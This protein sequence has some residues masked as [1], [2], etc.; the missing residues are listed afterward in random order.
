MVADLYLCWAHYYDYCD[1]FEK[2]ESV[3]RKGLDARA[4][5]IELIEQAHRQFGFQMSQRLL[6]KDEST[7]NKFRSSMEE[8]RLALTSLRAHRHRHVGSMRTGSAVKNHQPGRVEQHDSLIRKSNRKVQ[9][10]EDTGDAPTSPTASTSVVQSILNSTKKQENLREPGPWNKAKMKTTALFGGASA[11]KPSFP[12]LEDDAFPPIPLPD[13]ENN[14]ARGIQLPNDFIRKNLPQNEFLVPMHQD[15]DPAKNTIYRYDKFMV[16]PAADKS[17]SLEELRAYKWFKKHN[18]KNDFTQTQDAVWKNG[19][20]IPIRLPPHFVRKNAKQDD[21]TLDPINIEDALANG[22]RKFAFDINLIYTPNE[23]FSVEEILQ[24]KWLNG[25]LM[26]QKEAEMEL[27]CGFER[28][29]EIYNRNANR[30]SM[31]LGGRKSILPR[32]SN[33]PRKSMG[34]RKSIGVRQSLAP[35]PSLPEAVEEPQ[36]SL[37]GIGVAGGAVNRFSLPKRKSIYTAHTLETLTPI[38]ETPS[39]PCSR[40]KLEEDNEQASANHMKPTPV[41]F[42][43]FEDGEPTENDEQVFKVPQ[44]APLQKTRISTGFQDEDLDGCTTQTFNFFIKSQA[45][46]TPKVDKQHAKFTEPENISALQKGLDF[47][48]DCETSPG[49]EQNAAKQPFACGGSGFDG[50]PPFVL[51]QHEIYRQKLS[52]IMETT[53]ECATVSS[54][55]ATASSKSSSADDFDFTKHTNHQSSAAMSTYRQQTIINNTA[56]MSSSNVSVMSNRG[57]DTKKG[58]AFDIYQEDA[59]K[60]NNTTVSQQLPTHT[61]KIVDSSI[62][63]CSESDL[64]TFDKT[65]PAAAQFHIYEDEN[66]KKLEINEMQS[67]ESKGDTTLVKD[68]DPSNSKQNQ[69]VFEMS[70]CETAASAWSSKAGANNDVSSA[71]L[72]LTAASISSKIQSQSQPQQPPKSG[73][74]VFQEDTGLTLPAINFVEDRTAHLPFAP[75]IF[76]QSNLT[77]MMPSEKTEV[78]SMFMP[79]IPDIADEDA[80]KNMSKF[81]EHNASRVEP[82]QPINQSAVYNRSVFQLPAEDTVTNVFSMNFNDDKIE[83]NPNIPNPMQISLFNAGGNTSAIPMIPDM[84]TLPEINF[85]AEAAMSKE[86]LIANQSRL[87]SATSG[88][89]KTNANHSLFHGFPDDTQSKENQDQTLTQQNTNDSSKINH[90]KQANT[91]AGAHALQNQSTAQTENGR[92]DRS[93]ATKTTAKSSQ[94]KTNIDDDFF[95][96]MNTTQA[97]NPTT[98]A[99][100]LDVRPISPIKKSLSGNTQPV[101][102]GEIPTNNV[103]PKKVSPTLNNQSVSSKSKHTIDD[104]FYALIQSPIRKAERTLAESMVI[105]DTPPSPPAPSTVRPSINVDV[106]PHRIS[107]FQNPSTSSL[108][109]PMK[110][111]PIKISNIQTVTSAVAALPLNRKSSIDDA[112]RAFSEENP[113]TAMFSLHMPF[114]KNSTVLM[115]SNE[116]I[117][118]TSDD[119]KIDLSFSDETS[120]PKIQSK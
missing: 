70:Q 12:I 63:V 109:E 118:N 23:E 83:T 55:A 27:T 104:E 44:S 22:Q 42:Q 24:S 82:T 98:N 9:V 91:F 117:E 25:E 1:N 79:E 3:Y 86:S 14:Y 50:P 99:S 110:N 120:M 108:L 51:E 59:P 116:N 5:P 52:A 49:D 81:F 40:R 71:D 76:N 20:G 56:K 54:L 29:E 105:I 103:S 73:F 8:Q 67:N 46:S 57:N 115:A 114:I 17:Y 26:S 47:G 62:A 6:Y 84:P 69:S 31:A 96:M 16:F 58:V 89:N 106:K 77:Q 111:A 60:G 72:T 43:I 66:T 93:I 28:R 10:F 38:P 2:A 32:K 112:P 36:P 113:N 7:R 100:V 80:T 87:N 64:K 11:S 33:S 15:E 65:L 21:W 94:L 37:N 74:N 34:T 53:E 39:P 97:Q 45:I 102:T 18:I 119:F 85:Q 13:S 90:S 35:P 61:G 75:T 30:R 78:V 92:A 4:Q 48:S 95:T 19:Y 107:L 68:P 101:A 41:P 88:D